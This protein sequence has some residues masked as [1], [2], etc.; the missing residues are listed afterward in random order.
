MGAILG[1]LSQLLLVLC[2][3]GKGLR[4]IDGEQ[5]VEVCNAT[6]ESFKTFLVQGN[7]QHLVAEGLP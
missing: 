2:A 6:E 7:K 5:A 4:N 3:E 1:R